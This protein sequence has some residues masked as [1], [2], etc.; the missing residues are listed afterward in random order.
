M[1]SHARIEAQLRTSKW[2]PGPSR[3]G[4]TVW[5]GPGD[6]R[7][8]VSRKVAVF[9]NCRNGVKTGQRSHQIWHDLEMIIGHIRNHACD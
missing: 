9:H 7:C 5:L 4:E 1:N 8:T 6:L 2:S 3:E